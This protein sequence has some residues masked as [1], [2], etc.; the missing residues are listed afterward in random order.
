MRQSGL[1]LIGFLA[2][3][4]SQP[5]LLPAA[6][7]A[8]KIQTLLE[9]DKVPQQGFVGINIVDVASGATI[10]EYNSNK[11]FVPASNT[12]LFTSALGLLRLGPTYTYKTRVAGPKPDS[13]GVV[14]GN[15]YV[16]G[17]GDPN[18]SGRPIPYSVD[19]PDG[20]PLRVIELL[21]DQCVAA[22]VK[23]VAGDVVGD[24]TAYEWDPF[25]DGWAIDDPVWEYGAPVSAIS[26]N[27]NT[28]SLSVYPGDPAR[29]YLKPSLPYFQIDNRVTAGTPER[30]WIDRPGNGRQVHLWGTISPRSRGRGYSLAVDDPAFYAAV[31]FRDALMRRGVTVDGEASVR[32]RLPGEDLSPL[33]KGL[34]DLGIYWSAPLAESLR[35]LDKVSQNLHTEMLLREVG[36]VAGGEGTRAAGLKELGEFLKQIGISE[37]EVS[38]RDASGL[39]R[40]NLISPSAVVKLLRYMYGS[41]HRDLWISLLPVS[42]E[43]G[44]LKNRMK[45]SPAEGRIRAKTGSLTHVAALGGYAMRPDGRVYAFSFFANNQAV[46]GWEVRTFLDTLSNYLVE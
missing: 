17:G 18:L 41:K 5:A 26:L 44:T 28:V 21:A 42:G 2:G 16:V 29:V 23:R 35:V 3:V 31:A 38:V 1:L 12:K 20:D 43:D 22:G 8:A 34:A 37:D 30:M 36:R 13:A 15:L 25:A 10:F 27:D 6:D 19:E 39:S 7:I 45:K 40:M 11:L 33:P 4:V 32:H 24:D 46:A 9:K 14:R